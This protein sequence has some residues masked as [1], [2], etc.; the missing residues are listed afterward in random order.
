MYIYCFSLGIALP[1]GYGM[2][3]LDGL[4]TLEEAD[5]AA[6]KASEVKIAPW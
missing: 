4:R 5:I 2:N 3:E 1:D 6:V